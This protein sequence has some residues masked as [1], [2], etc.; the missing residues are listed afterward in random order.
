MASRSKDEKKELLHDE[1]VKKVLAGLERYKKDHPRA[2]IDAY[3][4]N[5]ASI[6]IRIIDPDFERMNPIE[7]DDLVWRYLD[8]LPD[9]LVSQVTM[10][11][12]ITDKEAEDS[13]ANWEFE[14]PTRSG[15]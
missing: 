3:R 5:P 9:R 15:F 11:V 12:L 6:R 2:T 4:Q 8:R 14:D 1:D 7:R 13:W 10:L